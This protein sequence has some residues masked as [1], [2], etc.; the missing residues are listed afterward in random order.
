LVEFTRQIPSQYKL[1]G[2]VGKRILK[3]AVGDLLPESIIYRKKMGF[4]TPLSAWFR[5]GDMETVEKLLLEERATER[6][7]FRPEGVKRLFAEHRS[8]YRDHADRIWRLLTFE[9][10][11]R[12]FLDSTA[13]ADVNREMGVLACWR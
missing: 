13:P 10:W 3:K 7:L 11:A 9:L 4:P 2:F 1:S 12:V 6:G 5:G 8:G